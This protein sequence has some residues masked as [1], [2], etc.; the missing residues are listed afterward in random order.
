MLGIGRED[1]GK[2]ERFRIGRCMFWSDKDGCEWK[3]VR[4]KSEWVY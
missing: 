3:C 4:R 2:E 1:F